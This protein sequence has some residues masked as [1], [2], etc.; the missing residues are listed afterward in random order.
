MPGEK[1]YPKSTTP[2]ILGSHNESNLTNIDDFNQQK[3][4]KVAQVDPRCLSCSGQVSSMLQTFKIAC[5]AY[6]PSDVHYRNIEFPRK[7][8]LAMRKFLVN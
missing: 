4:K 6:A 7:K 5:I 8:L 3:K 1:A 2:K